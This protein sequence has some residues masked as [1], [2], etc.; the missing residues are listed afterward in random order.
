[1]TIIDL[2]RHGELEGGER[3]RGNRDDGLT[4]EGRAAMDAVWEQVKERAETII[5]SPSIRCRQPAEAW[6]GE[7]SIPC[8]IEP[9]FREMGYGA[10]EGLSSEEIE[11]EFPGMLANWRANPVGMQIPG[12]ESLHAFNER[13]R[14][15]WHELLN[16]QRGRHVML[17]SHSGSMRLI[18][19]DVLNAPLASIRRFD[20]HYAS[21][22]RV[23]EESNILTLEFFNR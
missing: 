22:C 12:A 11:K 7:A 8:L 1:M 20:M 15:G 13:V 14:Q 6:A 17:L 9:R 23:K 21:W 18:L 3:Y 10:W 4:P 16:G 19:T 5:T 2:L